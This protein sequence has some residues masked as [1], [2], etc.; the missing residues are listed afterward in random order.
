MH[1]PPPVPPPLNIQT[2]ED[3]KTTIN[4]RAFRISTIKASGTISIYEENS[5]PYS[6]PIIIMFK[7]PDNLYL[8][9]NKPLRPIIFTLISNGENFYIFI[10]QENIIYTGKNKAL[11]ESPD[12]DVSLTPEFFLQALFT[13]HIPISYATSMEQSNEGYMLSVFNP[14]NNLNTITRKIWTQ[15]PYHYCIKELHY[16]SQGVM[17][18]EIK[19]DAFAF[20]KHNQSPIAH[21][22]FLRNI[23]TNVAIV[24]DFNK[25]LL[26]EDIDDSVFEFH[27]P[28]GVDVEVVE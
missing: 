26:N 24:L 3:L 27:F 13:R 14:E 11:L 1:A 4:N 17:L 25:V 21:T 28:E 8:K 2:A 22:I 6:Y 19:R 16:S 23:R 20:D 10:P 12:Y 15:Q 5:E 18:Y 9:A 7:K